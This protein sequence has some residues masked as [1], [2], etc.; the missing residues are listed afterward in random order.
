[1]LEASV[2]SDDGG[3][4]I[5]SN[6]SKKLLKAIGMSDGS[7]IVSLLTVIAVGKIWLKLFEDIIFFIPF[8]IFFRSLMF[9]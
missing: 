2:L 4:D 3:L 1:M 5:Y 8:H 9:S 7:V 6:F